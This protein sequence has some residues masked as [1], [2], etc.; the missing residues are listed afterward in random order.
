MIATLAYLALVGGS[1]YSVGWIINPSFNAFE[2]DRG[3][4]KKEKFSF[5]S[6]VYLAHMASSFMVLPAIGNI[7][8][9][10]YLKNKKS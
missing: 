2:V 8:W 4:F 6:G 1:A 5:K 9:A 7:G 3:D 10:V